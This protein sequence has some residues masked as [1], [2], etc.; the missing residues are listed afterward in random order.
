MVVMVS[1]SGV[2]LRRVLEGGSLVEEGVVPSTASPFS[3]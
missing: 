3:G 1:L 2:I